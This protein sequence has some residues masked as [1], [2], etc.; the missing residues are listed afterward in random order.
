MER[1]VLE[2]HDWKELKPNDDSEIVAL[3]LFTLQPESQRKAGRKRDHNDAFWVETTLSRDLARRGRWAQLA[4]SEKLK[5][6]FHFAQQRIII[7]GRKVRE[8]PMFWTTQSDLRDGPPDSYA[9]SKFPAP[10]AIVFSPGDELA[11]ASAHSREAA[12]LSK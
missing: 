7:A 5:A 10:N 11:V 9:S 6:M 4:K 2:F 1:L 8:A 3:L 12:G